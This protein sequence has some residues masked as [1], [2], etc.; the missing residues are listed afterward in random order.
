MLAL[1]GRLESSGGV[2]PS[3]E[4]LM[5]D[6]GLSSKSGIARL[7]GQCEQ[8]GRISRRRNRDRSISILVPVGPSG[9]AVLP[10]LQAFSDRELLNEVQRRGLLIIG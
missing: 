9:E 10:S 2:C 1:Q 3:F 7:V 5:V 8:K 4:E 6:L